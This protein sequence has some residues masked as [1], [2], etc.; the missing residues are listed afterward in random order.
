MVSRSGR[1][2]AGLSTDLVI[3]QALM[4][5]LKTSGGLTRGRG[6]TEQQ[7]LIWLLCMP[8]C[9]ETNR[10]IPTRLSKTRTCPTPDKAWRTHLSS[11][12]TL[13]TGILLQPT[14]TSQTSLRTWTLEL[15]ERRY[16]PRSMTGKSVIDYTFKRSSQAVTL[17]AK[18]YVRIAS[19]TVQINPQLLFQRL[20]VAYSTGPFLE[21]PANLTGSESDF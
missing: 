8:A 10:R 6:F 9:A 19:D 16:C 11:S 2:L 4:R 5:S 14:L 17:A 1:L 18:S 7:R 12:Q 15:L 3:D 21:R 13:Q 20:I